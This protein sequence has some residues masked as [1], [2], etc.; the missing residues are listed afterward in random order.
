MA[1]DPKDRMLIEGQKTFIIINAVGA[2]A[3]LAF[4]S[5]IWPYGGSTALKKGVLNGIVA[6]SLGV[7]LAALG[8]MMRDWAARMNPSKWLGRIFGQIRMWL[9]VIVAVCFLTGVIL[10]VIGGHDSLSN[11]AG[12]ASLRRR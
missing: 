5:A 2:M 6:F 9:P 10:P 11:S 3:L 1:D 4:L 12:Q 8:Y 7:L